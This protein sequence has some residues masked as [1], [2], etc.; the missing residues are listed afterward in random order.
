VSR[1]GRNREAVPKRNRDLCL[2]ARDL[3]HPGGP[4][5]VQRECSPQ[6]PQRLISRGAARSRA[7]LRSHSVL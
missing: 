3:D 4:W 6:I 2:Q 7:T 1:G 5:K